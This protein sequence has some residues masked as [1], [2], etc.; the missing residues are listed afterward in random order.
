MVTLASYFTLK[1]SNPLDL[2]FFTMRNSGIL[3]D[4]AFNVKSFG[5]DNFVLNIA[6]F[7]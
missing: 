4:S 7:S 5:G 2:S 3:V 1:Y 6:E